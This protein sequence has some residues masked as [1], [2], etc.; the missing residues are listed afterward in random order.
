MLV[1]VQ[2]EFI[3]TKLKG[4]TAGFAQFFLAHEYLVMSE[5]SHIFGSEGMS[6]M[7]SGS[8]GM[9]STGSS[10]GCLLI[11][12]DI[13]CFNFIDFIVDSKWCPSFYI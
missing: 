4:F 11:F 10:S 5:V 3:W 1:L 13:K 7:S 9:A 12:G 8:G 2:K 6:P